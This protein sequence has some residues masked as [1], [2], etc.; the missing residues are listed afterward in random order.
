[1]KKGDM[2]AFLISK[3]DLKSFKNEII[4]EITKIVKS[5]NEDSEVWLRTRDVCKLLKVSASTLQNLRNNGKM[6]FKKLNGIILYKRT[7][8]ESLI[9][10]SKK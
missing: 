4:L 3:D 10:N 9:D 7:D 2:E 1:M 8:I 5:K 6:P